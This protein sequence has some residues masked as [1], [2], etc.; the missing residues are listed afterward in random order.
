MT[1]GKGL[2]NVDW[3]I[4]VYRSL[5]AFIVL[6]ILARLEGNKQLS[7]LTFFNYV[8]GITI[9]SVAASLSVN[10]VVRLGDGVI[11]GFRS[12]AGAVRFP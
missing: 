9:G 5:V 8:T 3:L 10:R 11:G 12:G 1:R 4:P 2:Q 6:L 7:Q